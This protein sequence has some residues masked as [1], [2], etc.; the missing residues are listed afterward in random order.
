MAGNRLPRAFECLPDIRR[1]IGQRK[2]AFF[3]DFDGTLAPLV[4][5]PE[6]AELPEVTRELLDLL[7]HDHL[8]CLISGRAMADLRSMIGLDNVYYAADHGHYILGPPGSNVETE[9]GPEDRHE[10]EA[11]A[12]ELES[13]LHHIEGAVVETKGVSLSVHFRLVAE[14]ERPVVQKI[15]SEVVEAAPGL[16]VI[17]GKLVEDLVPALGWDKGRA[18]LWLLKR[19]RLEKRDSCPVCLGD[20]ST[21]EDMFTAVR[22]WGVS[23][24]VG[25]GD[26]DTRAHYVLKD[27]D[28]VASFL[29]ALV[30]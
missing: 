30:T 10:L 11:A 2:P 16:R 28:E 4:P 1:S 8:L 9:I 13:R 19:L 27:C 23:V 25:D 20:D 24:L 3:L 22:T 29:R 26:R 6:L 17:S 15:V 5:R 21:D 7:A 18:V 14:N 12:F